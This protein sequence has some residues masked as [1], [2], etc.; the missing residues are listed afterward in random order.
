MG[1]LRLRLGGLSPPKSKISMESGCISALE[2]DLV[3]SGR[4]GELFL[5]ERGF[6]GFEVGSI[7]GRRI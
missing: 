1:Y 6:H 7:K 3:R 2:G 4:K 5:M